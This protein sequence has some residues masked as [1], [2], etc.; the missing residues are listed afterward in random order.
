MCLQGF[1]KN[2]NYDYTNFDSFGWSL[3]SAFRLMTQD[4]WEML[5][6]QVLRVTGPYH[7]MF[8]I[9][10]IFL[11]SIYLVN[12]IL[13]IV[14]MS[15]D[16]LQKKSEEDAEAK[17]AEEAAYQE[18]QRQIEEDEQTARQ[19]RFAARE[20][21]T[22]HAAVAAGATIHHNS[23]TNSTS[24]ITQHPHQHHNQIVTATNHNYN[25]NN[26]NQPPNNSNN[27]FL[28]NNQQQ[29]QPPS[30]PASDH[31]IITTMTTD[32]PTP[33]GEVTS[34]T[35]D[36]QIVN[37]DQMNSDVNN[38]INNSKNNSAKNRKVSTIR[39]GHI[40]Q[41]NILSLSTKVSLYILEYSRCERL[42]QTRA[43]VYHV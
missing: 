18:S 15:Y 5:Y 2:P 42:Y 16:E 7:I 30:A 3:L 26:N 20:R 9:V 1:G 33:A 19:E 31:N 36:Q 12:L 8:F 39:T 11:G 29:Q 22:H 23:L 13:A 4:A 27:P 21:A 40:R 24:L 35:T 37:L 17:A 41:S 28:Q 34:T 14:A 6:Q 32:V 25:N 10:A 38:Q 43:D